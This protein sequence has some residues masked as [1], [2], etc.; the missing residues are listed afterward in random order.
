MS[1]LYVIQGFIIFV[2]NFSIYRDADDTIV[3]VDKEKKITNELTE[4]AKPKIVTEFCT[5]TK[6][7]V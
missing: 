3:I 1:A 6:N 5:Y 7:G 4:C 2:H